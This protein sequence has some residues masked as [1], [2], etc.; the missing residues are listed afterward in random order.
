V[1]ANP[2][3]TL[4]GL[5]EVEN[6][7]HLISFTAEKRLQVLDF[8]L[9]TTEKALLQFI[10]LV[11][12]F[13]D[14]VPQMTAMVQPLRKL[15]DMKKYKDSKKLNL[16]DESI[17]AFHFFRQAVSYCQE[18]YFLEDTTT[19]ILQ[20]DASDYDIGGYLYRITNHQLRIVRFFSK[21]L[22]GSQLKWSAREKECYG[23]Y[24]GVKLFLF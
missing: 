10:G 15:I 19:P 5:K 18:L 3:K 11:N 13:R 16:T 7:G 17:A 1:T 24:F 23:I 22:V 21:A 6:V 20:T 9:P 8:P 12:Y 4:L 2:R 14:H